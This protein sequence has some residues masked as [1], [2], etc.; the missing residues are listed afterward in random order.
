[1][2]ARGSYAGGRQ[3]TGGLDVNG[4][5]SITGA[6]KNVHLV[7]S[8]NADPINYKVG[9]TSY[10]LGANY[11]LN[12]D[13]SLFVRTSKGGR[14]IADRL[15]YSPF[16]DT[17]TGKLTTGLEAQAVATVKQHELGMKYR[18]KVAGGNFGLF[19]TLFQTTVDEYDYDQTRTI[20]PKLNVVGTK[21][22]GLE[23]ES[24]FSLG[25]FAINANAVYTDLKITRDLVGEAQNAA[26]LPTDTT[27]Y[28][29]VGKVPGGVPQWLFTI[30][31][32]YSFG[33]V[34]VGA[35][36]VGQTYVWNNNFDTAKVEGRSIV[37]AHVSYAFTDRASLTLNVGNVFD[38]IASSGGVGGP[39]L[40]N[41]QNVVELRP[42]SGRTISAT[43]RYAF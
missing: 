32:R 43:V 6:E 23:L 39:S 9:Y 10:S 3:V 16:V 31:P 7:D 4:D 8:A 21:A 40:L 13:L 24:A 26:R 22:K 41:G 35:S 28:S 20:G 27:N 33:A 5:G 37:N 18:G 38:K 19:A 1:M 25:N 34:T 17:R 30:T 42:E 36:L 14:A 2:R 12:T 29:T 11:R 15:L